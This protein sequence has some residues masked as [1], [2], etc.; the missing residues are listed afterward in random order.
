MCLLWAET[1]SNVFLF[2]T[3]LF[4]SFMTIFQHIKSIKLTLI[5]Y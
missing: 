1:T 4:D 2:D 3:L 5:K